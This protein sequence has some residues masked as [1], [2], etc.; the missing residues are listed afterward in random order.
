MKATYQCLFVFFIF[1]SS[2]LFPQESV[3]T[4][5][6]QKTLSV[7]PDTELIRI[8]I[9]FKDKKIF[10]A[11]EN[12]MMQS[13]SKSEKQTYFVRGLKQFADKKHANIIGI[14]REAEKRGNAKF[15]SHLWAA[16]SIICWASKSLI[17]DI[18]KLSGLQSIYW[19]R[20]FP[21]ENILDNSSSDINISNSNAVSKT[22]STT[23]EW[24][25]S[26]IK[27]PEVWNLGY[28]GQNVVVA[29]MDDGCNYNHP[30]L[31][32]HLWD[33]SNWYYDLNDNYA[34]DPGER[35][36]YHGWDF[37]GN[38]TNQDN[39]PIDG[40]SHG[41]RSAGIVAGDG[42][43]G[44]QTG[45]APDAKLMIIRCTDGESNMITAFQ[46][47]FDMID[48][49]ST[50]QKPNIITMSA[51]IKFYMTPK[52]EVWRDICYN[53]IKRLEIVHI[54]SIG[55]QGTYSTG[56]CNVYGNP[57]GYPIPY[58]I[59]APG[60][61][62]PAWLHPDQPAPLP[63]AAIDEHL[64]SVI[65]V[66]ATD[67]TDVIWNYSGK[68]PAAWE[69]IQ[70][71]YSCQNPIRSD[72][73]DYKYNTGSNSLIKPDVS[74]PAGDGMYSTSAS[75]GYTTYTGTS[76]ATPHVAGTAALILSANPS[77]KPAQISR[78]IQETAIDLDILGKDNL[79]GAGRVNA[80]EALKYTLEN[81][82]GTVTQDLT[83]PSSE[84]W[85]FEPG[86]TVTFENG[87]SL[88]VNG[89][90]DIN[91]TSGNKVTFDF[92]AKNENGIKINSG[93]TANF[94][95]AKIKN[96]YKGILS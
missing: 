16:N 36:N 17:H 43:G 18:S 20:D 45:V 3:I 74:A 87:A 35:L 58:N 75:G 91:G 47:F 56:G 63:T 92:V 4:P 11:D 6:L 72:Y 61:I 70:A 69:D 86:V 7:T 19:D 79:Y 31:A 96:A 80:Y 42:T 60:N 95:Y 88:I 90:L 71:T 25:V 22:T 46:W 37:V 68:G 13:M 28:T 94:T 39:N 64:N 52:Y 49:D 85:T 62:P 67:S 32:D 8:L 78:I 84:T 23:I 29:V 30:D 50:F 15:I 66:G 12:L 59:A 55:N 26:K 2:F 1:L 24:G 33:G 54:N 93:A 89:E 44:R 83:I 82:G 53:L 10:T 40:G 14:I 77:L 27:A 34:E 65:A 57:Y 21:E 41:T 9:H 5:A 48:Q 38:G 73:W 81:Y 76:A 51:S